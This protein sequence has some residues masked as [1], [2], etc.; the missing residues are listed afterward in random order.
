M[1][2]NFEVWKC[3][4][5]KEIYLDNSATTK[6]DERACQLAVKLMLEDYGNPS[7]L[8][9]K[10]LEA[11]IKTENARKQIADVLKCDPA[12]I[13]FTSGGTEANNTAIFGACEARKRYGNKIITTAFE[14]SSVI[15][16]FKELKKQGFNTVFVNP[17]KNGDILADDIINQIDDETILLS[18]MC[19]NNEIGTILPIDEIIKGARRKK[20][21]IL[22]HCDAVQAFCKIPLN[23]KKLDVDLMSVSSHKIHGPK[24]VGALY[25]KKGKRIIPRLFGGEQ[26]MRIRPG[27]ESTPLI[28]AFGLAAEIA[29]ERIN[30]GNEHLAK[31]CEYFDNQVQ[32]RDGI[33]LN[34]PKKS[35]PYIRNISVL[36]YRSEIML[37]TLEE[38]N[39]YVSS[40]SACAKGGKSHVLNS[41]GLASNMLDSAIRVSFNKDTSLD[42]IDE[43]F[44]AL[45]MAMKKII[46]TK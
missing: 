25:I 15:E 42:E 10:G 46:K 39:I 45:D 36:G 44:N 19:I 8:H 29:S 30:E 7:S 31:L 18:F 6:V 21:D 38:E 5:L 33:H 32:K 28:C 35:S 12:C 1:C 17:D 9:K 43:F 11:Q 41:M 22:I 24:G 20:P 2:F 26:Q 23:L 16:P 40:G 34:L 37:H 27:T 4:I 14:H 3:K 13:F